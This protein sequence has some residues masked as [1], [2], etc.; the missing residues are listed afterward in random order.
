MQRAKASAF[1]VLVDWESAATRAVDEPPVTADDGLPLLNAA[2]GRARLAVAM[3]TANARAAGGD[4][5]RSRRMARVLWSIM[6]SSGLEVVPSAS[7][8]AVAVLNLKAA[9]SSAGA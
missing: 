1:W 2:A 8:A 6:P 5:H 7:V 3:M 4:A 9:Q